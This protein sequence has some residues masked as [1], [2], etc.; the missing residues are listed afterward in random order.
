MSQRHV[1]IPH[2]ITPP[3]I[4]GWNWGAFLLTWIW[5]IGNN[6]WLTLFC[7]IPIV[8]IIGRFILGAK[9]NKLAWNNRHWPSVEAFKKTQRRWAIGGLVFWCSLILLVLVLFFGV[10]SNLENSKLSQ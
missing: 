8:G 2:E 4:E 1:T 7:F 9:G 10:T 5:G 3:E 6:V